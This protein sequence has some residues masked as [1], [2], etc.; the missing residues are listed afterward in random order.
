MMTSVTIHYV[1]RLRSIRDDGQNQRW[2]FD[3]VY[4]GGSFSLM[5]PYKSHEG[6]Y[7]SKAEAV[8]HIFSFDIDAEPAQM[9]ITV[10]DKHFN[11]TVFRPVKDALPLGLQLV[12]E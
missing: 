1:A 7:L 6:Q 10:G 5:L 3:F 11:I 2:Y 4:E 12:K 8:K 9:P